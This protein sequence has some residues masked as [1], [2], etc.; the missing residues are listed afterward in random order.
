M[1]ELLRGAPVAA[2]LTE[3]AAECAAALAERGV[4]PTLA[5]VRVGERPDDVAYERGACKRCEKAGIA[6]VRHILPGDC[7]QTDLMAVIEQV[8]A[9]AS[10][11]GCLLFRPLP[12]HLDGAAAAAALD[13]AKDVDGITAGSLFGVLSGE[14][15]GFPPATA[16]AVIELLDHYGIALSGAEVTVVGRSL[17]I[18]R[19]VSLMLQ[20]RDATVTMCHTRT[21]DLAAA[22][23]RADVLVVAAGRAG[24]IGAEAARAGQAVIDVG[25]N[26]DED[27][28][29]LVGDVAFDAVE[30][31]VAAITP[32]PGGIGAVTTA[33][34]AAHVVEAAERS[35]A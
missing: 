15:V 22:C 8:S 11:H 19:P 10:V 32:V 27:A 33:V 7:S 6:V 18:G 12:A 28:G 9:D 23:R 2:A 3:R 21:R 4:V 1:A 24:V 35:L 17:V 26:W 5:V 30:P 29:A 25:I 16:A 13:P 31:L 14:R 34:L 20:A